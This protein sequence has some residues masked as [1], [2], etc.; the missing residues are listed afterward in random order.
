MPT[1]FEL[2]RL[3]ARVK[4]AADPQ[5]APAPAPAPAPVPARV[6]KPVK[7][8]SPLHAVPNDFTPHV[9]DP[10]YVNSSPYPH[11]DRD[12]ISLRFGMNAV[13]DPKWPVND[14]RELPYFG[15]ENTTHRFVPQT[16]FPTRNTATYGN[17]LKKY[18][19]N[20]S[21]PATA[22]P[23]P[24]LGTRGHAYAAADKLYPSKFPIHA[25]ATHGKFPTS[26]PELLM[27]AITRPAGIIGSGL[28]TYARG[29]YEQ[30]L[31]NMRDTAFK[32]RTATPFYY[33]TDPRDG[34]PSVTS[35]GTPVVMRSVD[36]KEIERRPTAS[37][38]QS[39]TGGLQFPQAPVSMNT[40][41]T[42]LHEHVHTTQFDPEHH[43][44]GYKRQLDAEG[45][46]REFAESEL[47]AVTSEAGH[48]SDAYNYATGQ[49]PEGM[50]LGMTLQQLTEDLR[51]R[52]HIG[53]A[54]QMSAIMNDPDYRRRLERELNNSDPIY[55]QRTKQMTGKLFPSARQQIDPDTGA[56]YVQQPPREFSPHGDL[57]LDNSPLSIH[58]E[59]D[60]ERF[61][62]GAEGYSP[63]I[64][65]PD[66]SRGFGR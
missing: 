2:G 66:R 31:K 35:Q 33:T 25:L 38:M 1:A 23:G 13:R 8:A 34:D 52:G 5:T 41:A 53:G 4:V 19:A 6:P 46:Y 61:T 65:Y 10:T 26:T 22:Y 28:Q 24:E 64:K 17:F 20:D 30:R 40:P 27:Q 56:P 39:P 14:L 37:I 48:V 59:T 44:T 32:D 49:W 11:P 50:H 54:T 62:R 58:R 21:D 60:K 3:T 42:D 47:P 55:K 12:P 63:D 15:S 29:R 7:P 51:R 16:P 57:L 18:Y 45:Q 43:N 36:G 9:R